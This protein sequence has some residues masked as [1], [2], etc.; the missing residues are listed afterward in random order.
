MFDE[1]RKSSHRTEMYYHLFLQSSGTL[2]WLLHSIKAAFKPKCGT[3]ASDK[4]CYEYAV[5][6]SVTFTKT[7]LF[8]CS[9]SYPFYLVKASVFKMRF[10]S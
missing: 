4:K 9:N 8:Y 2:T 6:L 3:I 5:R 10:I 7:F 1:L